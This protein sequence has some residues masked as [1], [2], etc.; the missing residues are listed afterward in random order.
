MESKI[1]RALY[2]VIRR[3]EKC[4]ITFLRKLVS[5]VYKEKNMR[6]NVFNFKLD[7]KRPSRI[8]IP[9]VVNGDTSTQFVIQLQDDGSNMILS[10]TL[11]KV[12]AIFRRADGQVYVQ[13]MDHG[14]SFTNGTGIVTV[15]VYTSSFRTGE[16]TIELA[17]YS[18]E[19]SSDTEYEGLITTN[20]AFFTARNENLSDHAG[21]SLSQLPMLEQLIHDA[22]VAVENCN[23]ATTAA[24]AA[25]GSANAAAT[26]ANNAA[27]AA[28]GAAANANEKAT[29]ANSAATA[30]NN[31][32]SNANDKAG[33]ANSAATAANSA[34]ADASAAKTAA[35][36]AASSANSAASSAN[37]AASAANAAATA[38]AACTVNGLH[39]IH[40]GNGQTA[41]GQTGRV[42]DV[43]F[44]V[45]W[46]GDEEAAIKTS[47]DN[48]AVFAYLY[49]FD[50]IWTSVLFMET[51]RHTETIG[52]MSY[53]IVHMSVSNPYYGLI[54]FAHLNIPA[55]PGEGHHIT[56]EGE[57]GGT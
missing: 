15:D 18:R 51:H 39:I 50:E 32:A 38:A 46:A 31:A 54:G 56:I 37:T 53:T 27:T 2:E 52:G 11:D 7:I 6:K 20:Q 36:S 22:G 55:T 43:A 30:A 44:E 35:N 16:N 4:T 5:L 21:T 48:G 12:Y 3:G 42:Y 57:H 45:L 26:S 17:I 29:A 25:A 24:N 14:V 10:S 1:G 28:N 8:V 41:G 47:F 9:R 13:D 19:Q 40:T 49:D 34:A 33:L 23:T